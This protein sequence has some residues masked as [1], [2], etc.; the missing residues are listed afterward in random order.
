MVTALMLSVLI[1]VRSLSSG[2]RISS[3]RFLHFA[4]G[5]HFRIFKIIDVRTL[6]VPW[7]RAKTECVGVSMTGTL[8]EF[9]T[10]IK[11]RENLYPP[12]DSVFRLFHFK[13][14]CEA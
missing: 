3:K 12:C 9:N 1:S 13:E 2:P 7:I 14:E 11:R 4:H 10:E 5:P 6:T 8:A